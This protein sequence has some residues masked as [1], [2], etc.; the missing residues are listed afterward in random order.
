M[1]V[2][3]C[4]SER[5]SLR[6]WRHGWRVGIALARRKCLSQRLKCLKCTRS[7]RRHTAARRRLAR[8]RPRVV[9]VRC[10][11]WPRYSGLTLGPV[12]G[13][14]GAGPRSAGQAAPRSLRFWGA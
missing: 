12:L 11:Q 3:T 9:Q 4:T 1:Q 6:Y 2:I 7:T 13:A 14:Q 10:Q 8:C 5:A